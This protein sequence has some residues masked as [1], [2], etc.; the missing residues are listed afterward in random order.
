MNPCTLKKKKGEAFRVDPLT[1]LSIGTGVGGHSVG[2]ADIRYTVGLQMT[3]V[4]LE[5][6]PTEAYQLVVP[7]RGQALQ[8]PGCA[9]VLLVAWQVLP[10]FSF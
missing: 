4:L 10:F 3:K 2:Q 7:R 9:A 1:P 6:H 8:G 5:P